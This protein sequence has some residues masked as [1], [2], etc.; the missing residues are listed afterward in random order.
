MRSQQAQE[1]NPGLSPS[2]WTRNVITLAI[3]VCF[4][5]FGGGLQGGVSANFL[6]HDLGLGGDQ[7]LW[8]AG[9]REIPGLGLMFLAALVMRLPQSRRASLSL[10]IMGLGYGSYA[11]VH[12]YV[13]LIAMS[14]VASVGFHN[15]MPLR[16]SL[17]MGMVG[18]ERSGRVLGRL[19]SVGALAST[20]GLLVVVLFEERLGLRPF[21]AFGG[22]LLV[23]AAIVVH[24]LPRDI[25]ASTEQVPRMVLR[26]RYW[27]FYV[28]TLFE[29][30]R[31]Q[32]FYTF[33]AWVLVDTY[34]LDAQKIS[35]LLIIS[36]LVNFVISPHMGNWVDRFGER[37]TLT[38]SY[39]A[40]ALVFVGYA[41]IH[42]AWVLGALY[43]TINFLV[44]F[45]IG[46]HTYVNR[47]APDE[48][49]SPTLAA[50]VSI[51]HISS[52]SMSLVAGTL[53]R[54][55]GYEGLCWGAAGFI[56]LSIPFALAIRI[57]RAD[58]AA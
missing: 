32:V 24:Y 27:L 52:V 21:F 57:E 19:N 3:V 14:L 37:K 38:A 54:T 43:I 26:K 36:G 33:G 10:L 50:G 39:V 9:F 48:D 16:S 6:V 40:L 25:G 55:I 42:H 35:M 29:G 28:L 7:V 8:L 20:G 30:S 34:G 15:W 17:A 49:L 5:R 44:L 56:L 47:I 53:L 41:T 51:N 45:R 13:A 46:L 2:I 31:T 11:L 23:L 12:S 1:A 58:R 22:I 4:S 18:K